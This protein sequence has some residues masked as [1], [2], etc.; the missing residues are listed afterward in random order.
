MTEK[1]LGFGMMRVPLL[2]KDDQKSADMPRLEAMVDAFLA[3]GFRY[4]DTA[5]MY[6]DFCSERFI[7]EA[8]VKRHPREDF[9]LADKMP[10]SMLKREEDV[11]S[12]YNKQK[13]KTGVDFF[14][15][16]LMHDMNQGNYE[17]AKKMG[18]LDFG[19]RR[20]A[21]G[22]IRHLGFS[23]HDSADVLEQILEENPDMEFVQLQINY[24]DW[25]SE[26]V[27]SGKC[28]E[29]AKAHGVPVI[30]MEPVK[31]GTLAKVPEDVEKDMLAMHPDWSIASW[32]IRFAASLR[33]VKVVL[34]GM[35]SME[36]MEDNLACMQAFEPLGQ[37]EKDLLLQAARK[38]RERIAVPCTGCRYCV[39]ESTC[40]KNIPIPEYFALYN[41]QHLQMDRSWTPEWEY[42]SNYVEQ[43]YGS[44]GA[45]IAC[46]QCERVCP[47]HIAVSERMKDVKA[48]MEDR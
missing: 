27:Q 22:E 21:E 32:A 5:F 15:Y 31:G 1:K 2:D 35:S 34:S 42:Y 16:Y 8:L 20:K 23:F 17:I 36:Q 38:I 9:L 47:Q 33:N 18:A 12:I 48:L 41:T 46:R 24:L 19:R 4:F 10:L 7:K 29:V 39:E 25:D 11:A 30:V 26:G 6:H 3:A 45:C 28:Y 43:G 14:D 13:E 37:K 40:P 44:A